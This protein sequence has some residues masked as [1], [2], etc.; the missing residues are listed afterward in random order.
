MCR[1]YSSPEELL[2]F[3]QPA[4]RH[5]LVAHRIMQPSKTVSNSSTSRST[6]TR[7]PTAGAYRPRNQSFNLPKQVQLCCVN[8]QAQ[9]QAFVRFAVESGIASACARMTMRFG[10]Y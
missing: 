6:K 3:S 5:A 9:N 2:G 10:T 7:S 1:L 8:L 4:T